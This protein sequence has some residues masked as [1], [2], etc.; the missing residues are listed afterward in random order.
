MRILRS[1]LGL[2][3]FEVVF[4]AVFL[5]GIAVAIAQTYLETAGFL[6]LYTIEYFIELF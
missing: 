1:R 6:L 4:L 3:V 2:P 5:I